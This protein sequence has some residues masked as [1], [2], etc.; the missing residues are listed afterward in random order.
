MYFEEDREAAY[1]GSWDELIQK[2]RFYAAHERA[3]SEIAMG[4]Y[5]RCTR[6]AYRY[7]DRAVSALDLLNAQRVWPAANAS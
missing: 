4:G 3:R 5:R 6:S 7:V 2:L 1:F